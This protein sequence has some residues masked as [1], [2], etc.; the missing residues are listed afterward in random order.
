MDAV[1]YLK[2]RKR[3]VKTYCSL[4]LAP[5]NCDACPF[6]DKGSCRARYP[7]DMLSI[8]EKVAIVEK[9]SKGH[10]IKTNRQKFYEV[11]SETS[12]NDLFEAEQIEGTALFG[13]KQTAW[14]EQEYTAP[15]GE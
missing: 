10:P 2:E 4:E 14:W 15:K 7:D 6:D 3:I 9:W 11:F 13:I 1:L 5:A 8:E 12:V